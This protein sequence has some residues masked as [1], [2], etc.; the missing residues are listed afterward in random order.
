[1]Y[2]QPN[3]LLPQL[4]RRYVAWTER[5]VVRRCIELEIPDFT[6]WNRSACTPIGVEILPLPEC[7]TE[8]MLHRLY[9][10]SSADAPGFQPAS[11]LHIVSLRAAPYHDPYGIFIARDGS[12]P[13]GFCI[14]RNRPHGRGLVNGLGVLPDYRRAGVARALLRTTLLWL[15][16]KSSAE[17]VIRVHPENTRASRLYYTEGF[18]ERPS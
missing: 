2:A 1:M 15:K 3:L 9:N 4:V 16:E 14:G 12:R 8:W 7:G 11:Y 17:A 10:A 6:N 5:G 18:G 13:V